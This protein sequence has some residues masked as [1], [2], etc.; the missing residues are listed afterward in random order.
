MTASE[1]F[2]GWKQV[3]DIQEA[4]RLVK[5]ITDL[6]APVCPVI[7][8]VFKAFR[9]CPYSN[10]RVVIIGQDPYPNMHKG[11]PV[12]TGIA[13]ANA[14]SETILSPSL[15][16]LRESVN[17]LPPQHKA[18]NFDITLE[19][20]EE[21]GVLLLNTALTC[22]Q[23]KPGSHGLLWRHFTKT[24]L[25]NLSRCCPGLVYVLMGTAASSFESHI[26]KQ[27]NHVLYARHPAC[28]ARDGTKM[29]SDIWVEVNNILESINGYGI[30]W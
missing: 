27:S 11:V 1:Y 26:D 7:K 3:V 12:D 6:N 18:D 4:V 25:Q 8:D 19:R 21:Q 14:S 20:W 24:L 29:P 16:V 15:K 30:K 2:D 5:I 23:N 9:K 28:F 13:F 17:S 22:L 10:L